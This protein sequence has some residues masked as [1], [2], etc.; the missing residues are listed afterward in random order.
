MK[1]EIEKLKNNGIRIFLTPA[2]NYNCYFCHNEGQSKKIV[3]R[4]PIKFEVIQKFIDYG[5]RQITFTG[6]EPLICFENIKSIIN[7]ILKNYSEEVINE[8]DITI[9]TN[10]ALLTNDN[11]YY[12]KEVF[13]RFKKAKLNISVHSIDE[14]IYNEI[15][16]TENKFSILVKNIK[17]CLENNINLKLNFV[18]LKN[19][20]SSYEN[21]D[22]IMDFSSKHGVKHI[23]IIEM[24]ITE[25]NKEFYM[26]FFELT[27]LIN[28]LRHRAKIIRTESK[29]FISY[30]IEDKDINIDLI[31]C[32]CALGCNHCFETRE[33]EI[34]DNNTIQYCFMDKNIKL[35]IANCDLDKLYRDVYKSISKKIDEY[36]NFSPSLIFKPKFIVEKNVYKLKINQKTFDQIAKNNLVFLNEYTVEN[37]ISKNN[38]IKSEWDFRLEIPHQNKDASKIICFKKQFLKRGKLHFYNETYLDKIY[39]F[40][41]TRLSISRKKLC[42][43]DYIKLNENI[44]S[45]KIIEFREFENSEDYITL[46]KISISNNTEYILEITAK[47]DS[48]I[49]KKICKKYKI[50]LIDIINDDLYA[51]ERIKFFFKKYYVLIKTIKKNYYNNN[52]L[53]HNFNHIERVLL[54]AFKII[55]NEKIVINEDI[56]FISVL[57]HD[58]CRNSNTKNHGKEASEILK[59]YLLEDFSTK[60]I[61]K[62]S[63]AVKYHSHSNINRKKFNLETKILQDADFLD[64]FNMH[65]IYRTYFY[66]FLN[67]NIS[68][69]KILEHIID[70][71]LNANHNDFNFTF[72]RVFAINGWY[73][74]RNFIL[75]TEPDLKQIPE[76]PFF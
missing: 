49:L 4:E 73:S 45:E 43:M 50:T 37:Y 44:I 68:H 74:L 11:I 40:S 71:V 12:L 25:S 33:I 76:N 70:K 14:K 69:K 56:V 75:A 59:K 38:I 58:I 53:S 42:A 27:S 1:N 47:N 62:I 61:S 31:R 10:S 29:R 39:D 30:Y 48:E 52:D 20:N 72:S 15:T 54:N 34:M 35:D 55:F 28:N 65:M 7:S 8:L 3:K 22:K 16:R 51:D 41:R 67:K 26:D 9:V 17:K 18:L 32:T 57:M 36:G 5:I 21:I 6:G 19:K 13:P 23:K 24:L 60:D 63:N 66:N 64:C 46:K 2:C